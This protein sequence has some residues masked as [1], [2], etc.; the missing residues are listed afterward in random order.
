[1][2]QSLSLATDRYDGPILMIATT[3]LTTMVTL[4]A[5]MMMSGMK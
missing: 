5:M 3:T 4:I 2:K 1:M